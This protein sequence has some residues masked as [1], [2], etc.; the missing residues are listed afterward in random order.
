MK[1]SRSL[2]CT[3]TFRLS[4]YGPFSRDAIQSCCY[5]AAAKSTAGRVPACI[6]RL[7]ARR[8][9][10]AARKTG[11]R[12]RGK[13][14]WEEDALFDFDEIPRSGPRTVTKRASSV[15]LYL[16]LQCL[17]VTIEA[18]PIHCRGIKLRHLRPRNYCAA[19][20]RQSQKSRG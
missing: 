13:E 11:K 9:S 17:I 15:F 1:R 14:R 2:S 16:S 5:F 12:N 20:R 4:G 6:H 19:G 3:N 10:A 18:A 8:E 7:E